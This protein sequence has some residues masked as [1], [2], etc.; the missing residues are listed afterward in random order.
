[1]QLLDVVTTYL[2]WLLEKDIYMIILE[3]CKLPDASKEHNLYCIKLLRSPYGLRQFGWMRYNYCS[4]YL[5]RKDIKMRNYLH[6]YLLKV[7][8]TNLS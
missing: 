1:M 4:D 2:Y 6:V 3:G 8:L 5:I 7:P